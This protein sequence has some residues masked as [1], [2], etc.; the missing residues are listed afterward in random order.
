MA[1]EFR[2]LEGSVETSKIIGK[3]VLAAS[4]QRIGSIRAIYLNPNDLAVQGITVKRGAFEHDD[5]FS[6]SQIKSLGKDGAVL[7]VTPISELIG[8]KVYDAAGRNIGKVKRVQPGKNRIK[9]IVI[10]RGMLEKDL[11]VEEEEIAQIGDSVML[12][13]RVEA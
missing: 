9:S 1:Q 12:N 8:L 7:S 4:G 13:K 11:I 3:K 10:H 5:C 2:E 6:A